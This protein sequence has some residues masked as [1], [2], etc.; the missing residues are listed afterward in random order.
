MSVI[1]KKRLYT[2]ETITMFVI[3]ITMFEH[4][5]IQL[6]KSFNTVTG[7]TSYIEYNIHRASI[8]L[9]ECWLSSN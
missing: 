7:Y 1:K 9:V 8:I 2:V 6:L 3:G 4:D 5:S